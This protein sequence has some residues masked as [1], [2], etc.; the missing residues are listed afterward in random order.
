M[1]P[2]VSVLSFPVLFTPP[3]AH[4]IPPPRA[5]TGILK[6]VMKYL[7]QKDEKKHLKSEIAEIVSQY[8]IY[9][10]KHKS[11]EPHYD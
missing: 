11:Q 5:K 9:I 2:H 6:I 10:L 1:I 8:T 4:N 3:P 7:S